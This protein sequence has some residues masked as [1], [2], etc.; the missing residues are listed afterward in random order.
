MER[1]RFRRVASN[2]PVYVFKT[3]ASGLGASSTLQ[4][5]GLAFGGSGYKDL[6]YNLGYRLTGWP[7]IFWGSGDMVIER[8]L[9]LWGFRLWGGLPRVCKY[10]RKWA[11][12]TEDTGVCK[13]RA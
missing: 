4:V 8:S 13:C 2:L 5:L 12:G 11:F 10:T 9:H 6:V 1:S 7:S 3:W